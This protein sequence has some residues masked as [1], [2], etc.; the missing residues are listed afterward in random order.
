MCACAALFNLL[1]LRGISTFLDFEYQEELQLETGLSDLVASCRNFVFVL[2]DNV[3]SSK[4]C[5]RELEA[6]VDNRVNIILIVKEG[7][8]W[9]DEDGRK[10]S[11]FPGPNVIAELPEKIKPVFTRKAIHHSDEYYSSFIDMLMK[12]V[13]A[14][15]PLPPGE[16]TGANGT[17]CTQQQHTVPA[18]P[19]QTQQPW[20][21]LPLHAQQHTATSSAL[22]LHAQ[23]HP[24]A[25]TQPSFPSS[26]PLGGLASPSIGAPG[27]QVFHPGILPPNVAPH[28]ATATGGLYGG[29]VAIDGG[30]SALFTQLAQLHRSLDVR[31]DMAAMVAELSRMRQEQQQQ[32]QQLRADMMAELR[33]VRTDVLAELREVRRSRQAAADANGR[34]IE[35]QDGMQRTLLGL[36]SRLASS[37]TVQ[38]PPMLP[39]TFP[40]V[41]YPGYTPYPPTVSQPFPHTMPSMPL[42]PASSLPAMQELDMGRNGG[43]ASLVDLEGQWETSGPT[44]YSSK[45]QQ[46]QRQQQPF[47][48]RVGAGTLPPLVQ[49]EGFART[50]GS[51]GQRRA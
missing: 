12:K 50:R 40:S 35:A 4:W 10:S 1:V 29:G 19:P 46:Q 8:R 24:S 44:E 7:S 9:K 45:Q 37:L 51:A 38:P 26:L 22:P 25:G 31:H 36:Q 16:P 17:H 27:S 41:S 28:V 13:T 5:L 42:Q 49:G 15:K 6:A 34:I 14:N 21:A 30:N 11:P 20:S 48:R 47:L 18:P 43:Q 33:E 23:Q 39:H 32:M 2:T 3:L